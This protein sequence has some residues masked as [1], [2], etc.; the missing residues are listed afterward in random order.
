MHIRFLGRVS[1]HFGEQAQAETPLPAVVGFESEP[2]VSV[3]RRGGADDLLWSPKKWAEQGFVIH[4]AER[5]G[6]A[7]IHNP[8]QLIC[9]V[10][11]D[12]RELGIRRYVCVL[13][14]ATERFLQQNGVATVWRDEA[15][16]LY[17]S[18]GKIMSLGLRV[19]GGRT[20][21]GLAINVHNDLAPFCGIRVCG[22]QNAS[23]DRLKTEKSLENLFIEWV[24]EYKALLTST[25]ISKNLEPDFSL[26]L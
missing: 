15:P 16:G 14:K 8:G 11:H 6:Q 18:L 20:F 13:K 5:G 7:T 4:S 19:H 22:L 12:V 17:T 1:F 3:G 24:A 26:R 25:A 21:H 9:F 10:S 2:T 23:V